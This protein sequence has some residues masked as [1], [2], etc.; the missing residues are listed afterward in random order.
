[1][2]AAVVLQRADDRRAVL[3]AP[4]LLG[5]LGWLALGVADLPLVQRYLLLP[6]A[7]LALLA[8]A[9]PAI[10]PP[11]TA[12]RAAWLLLALIALLDGGLRLAAARDLRA[13]ARTVRAEQDAIARL[14]TQPAVARALSARCAVGVPR[15]RL[16][17][18][19]ALRAGVPLKTINLG[20]GA[21]VVAPTTRPAR[22]AVV[23]VARPLRHGALIAR[24]AGFAAY[25]TC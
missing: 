22:G 21:I 17:P 20:P 18:D 10:A 19:V 15:A 1:V 8:C 5:A 3:A 24:E 11:G 4:L 23:S 12:R 14:L 6:G 16:I 13:T 7:A 2:A 9:A 25:G